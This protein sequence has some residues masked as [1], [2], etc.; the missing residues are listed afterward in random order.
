MAAMTS[1]ANKECNDLFN[2]D[3]SDTDGVMVVTIGVLCIG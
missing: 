3:I 2:N 1:H